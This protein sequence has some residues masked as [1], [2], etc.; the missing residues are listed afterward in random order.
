MA[1]RVSDVASALGVSASTIRNWSTAYATH[2][3]TQAS[4]TGGERQYTD[5]DVAVLRMVAQLRREGLSQNAI[6]IRLQE[7]TFQDTETL[8]APAPAPLATVAEDR[9][10]ALLPL[11]VARQNSLDERIAALEARQHGEVDRLVYGVL[12]GVG[13]AVVLLALAITLGQL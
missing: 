2:L 10:D 12:L 11:V 6:Q 1:Y 7:T 8:I 5:L 9:T 13:I 4:G 3:A